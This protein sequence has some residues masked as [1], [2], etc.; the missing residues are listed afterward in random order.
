MPTPAGQPEIEWHSKLHIIKKTK[1][2]IQGPFCFDIKVN[3][4]LS[5]TNLLFYIPSQLF[6][7]IIGLL[8]ANSLPAHKSTV[9]NHE[10]A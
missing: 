7:I 8:V 10:C 2:T 6:I 1:K 3:T 9:I 4:D 5:H